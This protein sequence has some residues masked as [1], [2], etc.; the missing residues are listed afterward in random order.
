M[1]FKLD[2]VIYKKRREKVIG[3]MINV[4]VFFSCSILNGRFFGGFHI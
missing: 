3:D 1:I 2:Y 4:C